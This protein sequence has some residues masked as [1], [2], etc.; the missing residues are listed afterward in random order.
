MVDIYILNRDLNVI[1]IIDDYKSL[2]WTPRYFEP[3]DFEIYAV[4]TE[5]T[6]ELLQLDCYVTRPDSDMIGIIETVR[7]ESDPDSGDYVIATGRDLG[8]ILDRRIVWSLTNIEDTVE[9][10][11]RRLLTENFI[12][13]ALSYRKMENFVLGASQGFTETM[14]GQYGGDNILDIVVNL[15][16][17]NG[18]GFRVILNDEK[19]FEFQMYRGTDRSYNQTSNPFIV[20][21]PEFENIVSSNYIHDKSTLKNACTVWGEGEGFTLKTLAVG[22]ISGLDRREM[23]VEA[24]DITSELEDGSILGTTEYYDMLRQRGREE[25]A[26]NPETLSFEGEVESIRQFVF[27]RDYFL[28]DIVTVKNSYGVT[29]HPRVISVIQ[30]HDENGSLTIP[31]FSFMEVYE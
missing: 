12:S 5:K 3:G 29:E 4:A 27:G 25:L 20:F 23:F 8:S 9:N 16:K 17:Q 11:V 28:G 26:N 6:L 22:S 19:N 1:G 21:S 30:S 10:G 7:I 2:I 14:S 13:P 18:Y 31:A 24:M 15:C